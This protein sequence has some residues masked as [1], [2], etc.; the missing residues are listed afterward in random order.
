M[1]VKKKLKQIFC[2]AL[3]FAVAG[4]GGGDTG[5]GVAIFKTVVVNKPQITTDNPFISD[6]A[7]WTDTNGDGKTEVCGGDN[8]TIVNDF[9]NTAITV[10]AA[11]STIP[12]SS[13]LVETG[14]IT[15]RP[16]DTTTPDLPPIFREQPFTPNLLINPGETQSIAVEI[17]NHALKEFVATEILCTGIRWNFYVKISYNLVEINTGERK[18]IE[19]EMIVRFFDIDN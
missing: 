8:F 17:V 1:T 19:S 7:T 5:G 16:A 10:K 12:P 15:F 4:C 6:L 14:K 2:A 3:L 9:A 18:T 11:S 13:V